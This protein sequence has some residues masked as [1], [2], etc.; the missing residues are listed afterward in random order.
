VQYHFPYFRI[1][2]EEQIL[3]LNTLS[4]EPAVGFAADAARLDDPEPR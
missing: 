2:E 3:P 1:I 4:H